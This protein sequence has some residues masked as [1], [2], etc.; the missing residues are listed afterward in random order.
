MVTYFTISNIFE[1]I[2]LITF[3]LIQGKDKNKVVGTC[4]L[5]ITNEDGSAIQDTHCYLPVRYF[6]NFNLL[7]VVEIQ[8][9]LNK[10]K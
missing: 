8:L 9:G 4:Y 10:F 2:L 1:S 6:F 7:T 3:C 5:Q